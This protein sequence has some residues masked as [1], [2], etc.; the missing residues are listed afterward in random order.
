RLIHD[1]RQLRVHLQHAFLLVLAD[2]E[3][4]GGHRIA[5]AGHAVDVLDARDLPHALLDRAGQQVL[6]LARR[7]ARHADDHID[8]RHRDLRLLLARRRDDGDD[9][10]RER[11][12]GAERR[13]LR[14]QERLRDSSG[15]A[16]AYLASAALDT[17]ASV[18]AAEPAACGTM[19]TSPSRSPARTST[20]S[21]TAGPIR[22][23]RVST[24]SPC[25]R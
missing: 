9:T 7:R 6:R 14:A 1:G 17:T 22:T 21:S 11:R 2:L 23:H 10:D 4:H 12:E 15:D 13:E 16:H 18:A 3:A 8:H 24:A 20:E 19:M 5:V 25:R